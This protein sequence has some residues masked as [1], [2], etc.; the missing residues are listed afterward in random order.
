[1]AFLRGLLQGHSTVQIVEIG[2]EL[3]RHPP[4]VTTD[5]ARV[6]LDTLLSRLL[7]FE[8]N[9]WC[10]LE[11]TELLEAPLVLLYFVDHVICSHLLLLGHY[12]LPGKLLD[13]LLTVSLRQLCV[14]CSSVLAVL[15][16]LEILLAFLCYECVKLLLQLSV[17]DQCVSGDVVCLLCLRHLLRR[18]CAEVED[19]L[20]CRGD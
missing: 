2:W 16:S 5:N 11:V 4:I 13:R 17:L 9:L 10:L 7:S 19:A 15:R 6:L 14:L 3:V 18:R 8:S 12:L 20:L 1:M